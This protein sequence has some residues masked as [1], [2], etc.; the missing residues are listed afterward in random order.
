M[1][2]SKWVNFSAPRTPAK[3]SRNTRTLQI[4]KGLDKLKSLSKQEDQTFDNS[5]AR[6][7][8]LGWDETETKA[9]SSKNNMS[10]DGQGGSKLGAIDEDMA[11]GKALI[12]N[13]DDLFSSHEPLKGMVEEPDRQFLD[14]KEH[15]QSLQED[16]NEDLRWY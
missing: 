6:P 10:K 9:K 14:R 3:Q 1:T 15:E 2:R 13:E 12:S 8:L 4:S 7:Q 5:T 11:N 16:W